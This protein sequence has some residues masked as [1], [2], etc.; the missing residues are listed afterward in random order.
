MVR[1]WI[2]ALQIVGENHVLENIIGDVTDDGLHI[3]ADGGTSG[4]AARSGGDLVSVILL[5]WT[6]DD[7]R[8]LSAG[9]DAGGEFRYGFR[10]RLSGIEIADKQAFGG[11]R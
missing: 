2:L 5:T 9:L 8:D 10:S 4:G 11:E 6:G 7:R 3:D 1:I